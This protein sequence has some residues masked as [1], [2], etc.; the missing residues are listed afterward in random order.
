MSRRPPTRSIASAASTSPSNVARFPWR[1]SGTI[2]CQ[3]LPQKRSAIW[4]AHIRKGTTTRTMD[5]LRGLQHALERLNGLEPQETTWLLH[6]TLITWPSAAPFPN[7]QNHADWIAAFECGIVGQAA[8]VRAV[9][10][11]NRAHGTPRPRG[12]AI[13]RRPAH[14]LTRRPS[15]AQDARGPAPPGQDRSVQALAQRPT[16]AASWNFRRS[17]DR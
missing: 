8:R 11:R 12:G 17:G 7:H 5:L 2:E 10:P 15:R 3:A 1:C 16:S 9:T 14:H 13:L 6:P 4:I